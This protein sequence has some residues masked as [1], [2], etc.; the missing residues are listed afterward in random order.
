LRHTLIACA[1]GAPQLQV[2]ALSGPARGAQI[3]RIW[4]AS[5]LIAWQARLKPKLRDPGMRMLAVTWTN[6]A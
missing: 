6:D 4:A 1:P 3:T 5:V 2:I